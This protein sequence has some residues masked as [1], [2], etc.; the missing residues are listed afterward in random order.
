MQTKFNQ[1]ILRRLGE[2]YKFWNESLKVYSSLEEF[3]PNVNALIQS[4]RNITFIIQANKNLIPGFDKWYESK[5]N[6]MRSDD[7]LRW[8]VSKRNQI[9][10]QEDLALKSIAKVSI[11][12]WVDVEIGNFEVS[13]TKSNEQISEE[14]LLSIDSRRR[15]LIFK[16]REPLLLIERTWFEKDLPEKEFL[17]ALAYCYQRLKA[18]ALE[19]LSLTGEDVDNIKIEKDDAIFLKPIPKKSRIISIDLKNGCILDMLRKEIP[20]N[21][22]DGKKAAKRYKFKEKFPKSSDPEVLF[23]Y[24]KNT[25]HLI[26]QRDGEHVPTVWFFYDSKEPTF[27]SFLVEDKTQQYAFIRKIADDVKV[28]GVTALI[29]I[30]DEW[31]YHQDKKGKI[32]KG[33]AIAITYLSKN[34]DYKSDMTPYVRL[35]FGKIILRPSRIEKDLSQANWLKPIRDSWALD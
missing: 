8:L 7:V 34:G 16:L 22:Q 6:E 14:F 18:I 29:F 35:P 23:D 13:A 28:Q 1:T 26:I 25:A 31:L 15:E 32:Q 33:E 19:A 2:S 4:L 17:E 3:L 5:E 30:L 24:I 10:K 9:T 21:P 12:N 27:M 20:F 11:S